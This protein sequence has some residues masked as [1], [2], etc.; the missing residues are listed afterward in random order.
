MYGQIIASGTVQSALHKHEHKD[1]P[2]HHFTEP[3]NT[4]TDRNVDLNE[5]L[6]LHN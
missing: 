1:R 3:W 6:R 5:H 2:G 4:T